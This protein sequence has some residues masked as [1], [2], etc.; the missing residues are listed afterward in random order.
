[1]HEVT[2]K[3]E[4]ALNRTLAKLRDFL[5]ESVTFDFTEVHIFKRICLL[6]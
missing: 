1:M 2:K 3:L 6:S 4:A 5:D